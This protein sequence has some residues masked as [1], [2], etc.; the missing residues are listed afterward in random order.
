[1]ERT[2]NNIGLL[3]NH[4]H[5]NDLPPTETTALKSALSPLTSDMSITEMIHDQTL[6]LE[7]EPRVHI[8]DS[9]AFSKPLE[10]I[11]RNPNRELSTENGSTKDRKDR[12]SD[13][14]KCNQA[15]PDS[16]SDKIKNKAVDRCAIDESKC[17]ISAEDFPRDDCGLQNVKNDSY[18]QL[19]DAKLPI[20]F[21]SSWE[22]ESSEGSSFI[23]EDF[24]HQMNYGKCSRAEMKV[25]CPIEAQIHEEVA[26]ETNGYVIPPTEA[27]VS[28]KE[29]LET[30]G[31]VLHPIE[32]AASKEAAHETNGYVLHPVEV[33]VSKEDALETK[34]IK[35]PDLKEVAHFTNG[36]VLHPIETPVSIELAHEPNDYMFH[37]IDT[38]ILKEVAHVPNGSVFSPIEAPVSKEVTQE[39]S[40][41]VLHPTDTPVSKE[42]AHETNGYVLHPILAPV[43]KEVAHETNGYVF[44]PIEA[45]VS[46]GVAQE[47][48]GYVL[49]PTGTPVSKEVAHETNRYLFLPIK[50]PVSK[51]VTHEANDFMFHKIDTPVSKE[52]KRETNGSVL[53]PIDCSVLNGVARET[54]ECVPHSNTFTDFT[55]SSEDENYV[56]HDVIGQVNDNKG[57]STTGNK[58]SASCENV[59]NINLGDVFST[60]VMV[61]ARNCEQVGYNVQLEVCHLGKD[62]EC[63]SNQETAS[64]DSDGYVHHS[65][66]CSRKFCN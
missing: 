55:L 17:E 45:P 10:V 26:L 33:P 53:H 28:I 30:N 42:V 44:R 50:A 64:N 56:P 65:V 31:Y 66:A 40:G 5:E 29:T 6:E 52:V 24:N 57:T 12:S 39:P 19:N 51:E 35:A 46:N 54:C 59:A 37:I 2:E 58:T 8:G 43:S 3:I 25:P 63:S 23:G 11:V 48:S 62:K 21:Q 20:N 9:V 61:T 36:Y 60:E 49:H 27:P 38:P 1:M 7:N 34:P 47:P 18:I 15:S 14:V 4:H 13:Y 16:D 41:Y 32:A 22:I